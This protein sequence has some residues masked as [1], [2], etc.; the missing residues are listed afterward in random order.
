VYAKQVI[1][2]AQ[3]L[4]ASLGEKGIRPIT[5]GTDTHLSLHDLQGI[6]VTGKDAEA[7][8]SAA[9][10]VLNK[11]AIPFDPQPPNTASGIRVGTPGVTTQGMGTAEMEVIADLIAQAVTQ[12]DG[13]PDNPKSKEIRGQVSDLV[14][15]FPAYPRTNS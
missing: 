15:R 11:N 6:G 9:G 8:A 2:N 13:D 4:A 12:T 5:G 14:G 7:R 3:Q 1:A 10:I